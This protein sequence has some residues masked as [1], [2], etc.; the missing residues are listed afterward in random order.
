M[1]MEVR[2]RLNSNLKYI[3]IKM[4]TLTRENEKLRIKRVRAVAAEPP[5]ARPA[6]SAEV[7]YSSA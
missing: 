6:R 4:L 2:M 7:R 3:S 1:M 5:Q